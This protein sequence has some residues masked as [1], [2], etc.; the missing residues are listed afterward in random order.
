MKHRP[1]ANT[2]TQ[3]VHTTTL[4][5]K[6]FPNIE[7]V[8]NYFLQPLLPANPVE[9][10]LM[11]KIIV[12]DMSTCS[13]TYASTMP[14]WAV[15]QYFDPEAEKQRVAIHDYQQ[16][17][18]REMRCM[19]NTKLVDSLQL[20]LKSCTDVVTAFKHMLVNGLE[21]YLD[22]QFVAPFPHADWP[23]QFFMQ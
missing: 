12:E 9:E 14:D 22:K 4:L 1:E 2:Q 3:T 20:P 19:D 18:L 8:P 6:V 17:E 15:E 7:A 10:S 11:K 16:T 5:V 21:D 13:Q 23:K